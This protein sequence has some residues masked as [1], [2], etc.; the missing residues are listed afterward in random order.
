MV[1]RRMLKRH[2]SVSASS[3]KAPQSIS[4][5]EYVHYVAPKTKFTTIRSVFPPAAITLGR[6]AMDRYGDLISDFELVSSK[7]DRIPVSLRILMERWGRYFVQLLA[8]G[9][10]QA[11]DRFERDQQLDSESTRNAS[12]ASESMN[13]ANK[14]QNKLRSSMSTCG[15]SSISS[16]NS[17]VSINQNKPSKKG[18]HQSSYHVSIPAPSKYSKEPPQFRLPFQELSLTN[19]SVSEKANETINQHFEETKRG[20]ETNNNEKLPDLPGSSHIKDEQPDTSR[21]GSVSSFSSSNSLLNSH[22]QNIPPQL[23]LPNE[24]IPAVPAST[25]FRG[26]SRK[27]SADLNSPRAS[28]MYTL[29]ALRNIPATKS[30]RESPFSSP[31]ASVSGRPCTNGKRI[32][33]SSNSKLET[34]LSFY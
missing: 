11:V 26:S 3:D 27:N 33:E 22:L 18:H 6:N 23:P 2:H 5:S 7:G 32:T 31:R 28:L 14:T 9:Y 20:I 19:N 1:K 21:K 10:V 13:S 34:K 8:K 16:S 4:F 24:P 15:G 25:S 17:E 29:T 30:P 12:S